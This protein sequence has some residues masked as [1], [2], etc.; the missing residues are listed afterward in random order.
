MSYF[1]INNEA[2]GEEI[3]RKMYDIMNPGNVTSN[4]LFGWGTDSKGQSYIDVDIDMVCPVYVNENFQKVID[5]VGA[6]LGIE[7]K[8]EG[9]ALRQYLE[10]GQVVLGNLIP[11]TLE[12][13]TP[14]FEKPNIYG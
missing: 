5:E 4:T 8:T 13:F 12:E 1:K 14:Y 10:T 3:S 7:P 11:S 2:Q 6:M 9:K